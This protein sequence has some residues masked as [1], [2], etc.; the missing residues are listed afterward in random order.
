M[1]TLDVLSKPNKHTFTI[2]VLKPRL[3]MSCEE[4]ICLV[5]FLTASR[6]ISVLL[7]LPRVSVLL[8]QVPQEFLLLESEL[9]GTLVGFD[10]CSAAG[11]LA[12]PTR[13]TS[14]RL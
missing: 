3:A 12:T 14:L 7:D 11:L 2:P 6:L 1:F 13:V 9:V 4:A 5:R 8:L 10:L